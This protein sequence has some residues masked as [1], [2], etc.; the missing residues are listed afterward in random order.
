VVPAVYLVFAADHHADKTLAGES[1]G[2]DPYAMR[3][4]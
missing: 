1:V 4:V 3:E 2:T